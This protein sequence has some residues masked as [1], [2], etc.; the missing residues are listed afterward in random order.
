MPHSLRPNCH[1]QCR[2]R[3]TRRFESLEARQ[4]LASDLVITEMVASNRQGLRDEDGDRSDWLEIYNS[5]SELIDLGGYYPTDD[6][7]NLT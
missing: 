3:S 4:M 5:G 1:S 7:D 6:A 2:R